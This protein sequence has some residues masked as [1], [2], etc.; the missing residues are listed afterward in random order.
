LHRC[1][2]TASIGVKKVTRTSPELTVHLPTTD[3]STQLHHVCG[4]RADWRR[5]HSTPRRLLQV[6]IRTTT[7]VE[8]T[9]RCIVGGRERGVVESNADRHETRSGSSP[10]VVIISTHAQ[11]FQL[12]VKGSQIAAITLSRQGAEARVSCVRHGRIG[13]RRHTNKLQVAGARTVLHASQIRNA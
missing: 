3:H 9:R 5:A 1:R 13:T 2:L 11:G 10:E 4:E 8:V 6:S 12:P 7:L